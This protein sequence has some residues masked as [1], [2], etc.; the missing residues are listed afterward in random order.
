MKWLHGIARSI[1]GSR[2]QRSRTWKIGALVMLSASFFYF[3][4][5]VS[6]A[7]Q[8]GLSS[9]EREV[10]AFELDDINQQP[11]SAESLQGKPWVINFWATWCPPCIEEIPS[12]NAAWKTL[13]AE[14]VGMLAINAGE[15]EQ[16]VA[17]FLKKVAIDF[18]V[19]LGDAAT[20]LPD[21]SVRGLPTTV[22]IDASGNVVLEALGPR[23]WDDEVIIEQILALR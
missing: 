6:V 20:T 12:M 15:G 3:A 14:G 8:R 16:A 5:T 11:W 17:A 9:V 10:P 18:P 13:E 1:T 4:T 21:W 2:Q 23:E 22:I 7:Q 19:V